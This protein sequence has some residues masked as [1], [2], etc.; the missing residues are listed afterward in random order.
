MRWKVVIIFIVLV[1]LI[2]TTSQSTYIETNFELYYYCAAGER[3]T[4]SYALYIKQALAPLGI[5]VR[6]YAKPFGQF[7]ADLVHQST[8][9][10]F[11]LIHSRIHNYI[12]PS[13]MFDFASPIPNLVANRYLSDS[14]YG[15]QVLQLDD[16]EWSDWQNYD[17]GYRQEEINSYIRDIDTADNITKAYQDFND[18][19]MENLLYE[20]PLVSK[21]TRIAMWDGYRGSDHSY[22][23]TD[24]IIRAISL[25]AHWDSNPEGREGNSTHLNLAIPAPR[26]YVFD[27]YQSIDAATRSLT[28]FTH[29]SLLSFDPEGRPH[30]SLAWNFYNRDTMLDHDHNSSTADIEVTQYSFLLGNNSYWSENNQTTSEEKL[31]ATDLTLALDLFKVIR[32]RN[33]TRIP[34][35]EWIDEVLA[36]NSTTTLTRDDT[37]NIYMN[38]SDSANLRFIGELKPI[39]HHLLGG[40]L[41]FNETN[42]TLS[43]DMP[44]HPWNSEEWDH[45][46]S[47]EGHS[48]VGEFALVLLQEERLDFRA[49]ADYW[50]PNE[51]DISEYY[52]ASDP[53][54]STIETDEQ[55][56][57][58][59]WGGSSDYDQDPYY[60]A[61]S[62]SDLKSTFHSID[63]YSLKLIED[64]N[65]ELIQFE[66]GELDAFV[67]T[68]LGAEQVAA[69]IEDERFSVRIQNRSFQT[70]ILIFNLKHEDLAKI[71]VRK[72]INVGMDRE[73]FVQ[74]QDGFATPSYSI[75]NIEGIQSI[76]SYSYETA[77]DLMRL[78]GYQAADT[79]VVH[80]YDGFG[81][82]SG[83]PTIPFTLETMLLFLAALI[84]GITYFVLKRMVKR[85]NNSEPAQR[86]KYQAEPYKIPKTDPLLPL[87]TIEEMRDLIYF[88]STTIS[89]ED[90]EKII[91]QNA[92]IFDLM[93][94]K[95]YN[96]ALE[97]IW[98]ILQI[99]LHNT[100]LLQ[101]FAIAKQN[102][103][104]YHYALELY[105]I[106]LDLD[107]SL[108]NIAVRRDELL[109]FTRN[110]EI[111][112]LSP[113]FIEKFVRKM[114]KVSYND[115]AYLLNSTVERLKE[116]L[117][118]LEDL[119]KYL[120]TEDGVQYRTEFE[121][122]EYHD[123]KCEICKSDS[124]TNDNPRT[125][126]TYCGHS[127]H[128]KEFVSWIELKHS[129]PVCRAII[130]WS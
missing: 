30:P 25:G 9:R 113:Y 22:W 11:D 47:Y 43:V 127:F 29:S 54:I 95:E 46:E 28:Q 101:S 21:V 123:I 120:L 102:L 7:V 119:T 84:I 24:G 87:P 75:T 50:Y 121:S 109:M 77:R 125:E 90:K 103:Q 6:I 1:A 86:R 92:K 111:S 97:L 129:C 65:N 60:W 32:S 34:Y 53:N 4:E 112:L 5:D 49:R 117:Y 82:F 14:F 74:I 56:A 91:N 16:K 78:E 79:N 37:L 3:T 38:S 100:S 67:S 99:D 81:T 107:P 68:R 26:E 20:I 41:H 88:Y 71:N 126:C 18:F 63:T 89:P 96:L 45:W 130:E 44:F 64:V 106:I 110:K 52:N 83:D 17:V 116:Y 57:L 33:D 13:T 40:L 93:K 27:P 15:S 58:S 36:Y 39:P 10:P 61:F 80:P 114:G 72:A 69:H 59:L 19:Y 124:Y 66:A 118:D 8:G 76:I 31:D 94:E 128:Y 2:P 115:L 104:E 42:S 55:V 35:I 62:G 98:S 108:R 73:V 105:D 48:L 51:W 85:R 12:E 23:D 70:E 122:S